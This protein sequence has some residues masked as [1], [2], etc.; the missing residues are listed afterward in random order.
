MTQASRPPKVPYRLSEIVGIG[1][2]VHELAAFLSLF[3]FFLFAL[4]ARVF[5]LVL[6]L[7]EDLLNFLFLFGCSL[8][9]SGLSSFSVS[10]CTCSL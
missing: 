5:R 1:H 2:L 10:R 9:S 7:V 4:L 3:F 6:A 8:E